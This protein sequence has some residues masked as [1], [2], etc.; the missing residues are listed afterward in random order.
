MKKKIIVALIAV[1]LI[2]VLAVTFAA[3][4]KKK[5]SDSS[6]SA[7][8]RD[9]SKVAVYSMD[10]SSIDGYADK[11]VTNGT[12]AQTYD[13]LIEYIKGESDATKRFALMHK[14]EDLLMDTGCIVPL[15]Y[16]TDLYM[17]KS[18]ITGFFSSP[19]GYKF[20]K[21]TLVGGSDTNINVVLASEP[22]SIDP[23]LNSAV[24]GATIISHCFSGL[25]R[26]N[27]DSHGELVLEPDCAVSAP[28]KVTLENGKTEYTFTLRS[29]LTWSD[30][31]ALKASDF[32]KAWDRAI[33]EETAAD[34]GYMFEVIDGYADGQLNVTVDDAAGTIKVVLPVDVTYFL[35]LCAFPTY[36]PVPA[37]AYTDEAWATK[38]NTYIGNG[39]YKL[40]SWDHNNKM[41][42]EKNDLYWDATN[43]SM[44]KITNKLSDDSVNDLA[45][46]K[47]GDY[48]FI[49]DVPTEEIATLK[50]T[51]PTE[52]HVDGQLGTYYVIF[53][54]N[55]DILPSSYTN[56]KTDAEIAN[57]LKEVRKA[58]SLLIDRNYIVEEIGQ[59][60][61]VPAASFVAMGLT[62]ADG[63]TEFY[64]NANKSGANYGY[65]SVAKADFASNVQSAIT[66]LKKYYTYT[67]DN[68]QVKFT[69]F[70]KMTYLY[71]T[72]EGHKVIGEYIQGRFKLVGIDMSLQN[73]EWN[74]FLDTRKEGDYTIARNGWLGDYNDP[75]SFLDMWTTGSGNN[76]AQFGK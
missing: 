68:G 66:T 15:Y 36:F 70:P 65:Y 46:Y 55:M 73:Q 76:D 28:T 6:E 72:S 34:Y 58:L 39:A 13:K 24:D 35:E 67:E 9:L 60:G 50:T 14:A 25:Y 49:D 54:N 38:V 2:A 33:D 45:G 51:Y 61:Q 22:D 18:N 71:N 42:F 7:K 56:G 75:I 74:T 37:V 1:L 43:V 40:T 69:N 20:F 41:V 12:W 8:E 5:G 47:N 48:D 30:G 63:V 27:L 16:Y 11:S 3:C 21:N 52:F 26:W 19:L 10:L 53:N 23:A 44:K 17:V 32:K 59:A 4:S 57:A 64:K 29:G 31:T 62:D